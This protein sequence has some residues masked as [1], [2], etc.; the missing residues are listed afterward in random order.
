MAKIGDV[1]LPTTFTSSPEQIELLTLLGLAFPNPAENAVTIPYTIPA[2]TNSAIL[3]I[4]EVAT[5]RLVREVQLNLKA[6]QVQVDLTHISSG[7]YTYTLLLDGVP[8][9]TKKLVVI[10]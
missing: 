6:E 10:K 8:N 5:G 2:G 1:G 4:A 7:L 3:R 9:A